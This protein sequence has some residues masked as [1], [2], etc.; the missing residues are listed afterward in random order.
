LILGI[1]AA[2]AFSLSAISYEYFTVT[3]GNMLALSVEDVH[4]NSQIQASD[5][6]HILVNKL[7]GVAANLEVISTAPSVLQHNLTLAKH[8][9]DVGQNSSRDLSSYYFWVDGKGTV[10]LVS[11]G[12]SKVL[13]SGVGTNASQ[14]PFYTGPKQS[15]SLSYSTATPS[16]SNASRVFVFV[17]QPILV[18][19]GSRGGQRTETFDGAVSAAIDLTT[20]GRL[21]SSQLSSQF[22]SSLGILDKNGVILYSG[23]ESF[24]GQNVQN[25]RVQSLLPPSIRDTFNGLIQRSLNGNA[26]VEDFSYQG[27]STTI[28]YQPVIVSDPG[29]HNNSK[30]FGVLYVSEPDIIAGS[31][32][33]LIQEQRL[34]STAIIVAIGAIST[35]AGF[36]VLR[37]NQRLDDVVKKKTSD[38]IVANEQL[39]AQA[40]AQ[41]DLINIAAHELRTP[42]QSILAN[43]ELLRDAMRPGSLEH[44]IPRLPAG[45]GAYPS[46]TTSSV[47]K[48]PQ[49][50]DKE[51]LELVSSTYRN[52]ERL[53]KL[54]QNLLDVARIDSNTLRLE[55]ETFD[56]D[57]KIRNAIADVRSLAVT[58]G[59]YHKGIEMVFEPDGTGIK[60]LADRTKVYEVM[61]NV[62]RNA[63]R[64]SE[65][66]GRI[67][68]SA[69][70]A[71]GFAEVQIRDEGTGIDPEI[72]PKLFGK[73]ATKSGTGLGLF[74]SKNYVEAQGG[75]MWAENNRDGKGAT[76]SFTLPLARDGPSG[77]N[78]GARG[79][80]GERD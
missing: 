20:L 10:L 30:Q 12:T 17:S 69:R 40:Q 72:L 74:I 64:H 80:L 52:A 27:N 7:E 58:N 75:R 26:G 44:Q 25:S 28:A 11:D 33:G 71:D 32:V 29:G 13:T 36:V 49:I 14:R 68:V 45:A 6:S 9:F 76:F 47:G 15:L 59:G 24:I 54:T 56:L 43:A 18:E 53:E 60:V 62:L 63:M 61:S 51:I 66:G 57:E 35:G 23:T 16:L 5:M 79:A 41:K 4:T 50:E 19:T 65:D 2:V 70:R 48:S 21:L 31:V 42:T 22:R 8:L 73:F 77:D 37:W 39:A 3:A 34:T 46:K 38:L 67:V 78:D 1:V 55:T